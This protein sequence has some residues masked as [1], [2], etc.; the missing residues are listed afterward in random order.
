ML[1]IK[2]ISLFLFI[3]LLLSACGKKTQDAE[4]QEPNPNIVELSAEQMKQI[5]LDTAKFQEEK[6]DITLGGKISFDKDY[7]SQVYSLVSG[8]VIRVNAS[9]GDFVKKGEVLAVLRSGDIGDYESQDDVA[10]AQLRTSKRNLDIAQELY[11]TKVYSDK[12]VMQAQNDYKAAQDNLQKIETYLKT[13]GVSDSA[14]NAE[15]RIVSPIDG[16]VVAKTINEGMNIRPDNT[17][18]VFTVSALGTIWVLANIYENDIPQVEI[19]DSVEV[20]AVAYPDKPYRGIISNIS[21]ILDSTA[22]TLQA[23]VVLTNTGNLLKPGMF[24]TVKVHV[25]KHKKAIAVPKEAL[26][27]YDNN[28]YIMLSKGKGLFE[29]KLVTIEGS[30]DNVSYISKGLSTGDIVVGKGSL[31]VLG[32]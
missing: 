4:Q 31:Y 21:N 16:Y 6:T 26:V 9:L 18:S 22:S 12:D 28:F 3:A 15:Y 27:F 5:T 30:N 2:S 24:S 29:R 14:K 1:R 11:K 7:L 10:Q 20:S 17:N 8:N 19:N 25:D 13:Y 23:R 32:Q